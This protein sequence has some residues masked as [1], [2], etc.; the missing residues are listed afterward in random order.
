VRL[1]L[2]VVTENMCLHVIT[3][4]P[5]PAVELMASNRGVERRP[6]AV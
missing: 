4:L 5:R 1:V 3:D 6:I 2:G